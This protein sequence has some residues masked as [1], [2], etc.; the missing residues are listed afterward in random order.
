MASK[1]GWSIAGN[2]PQFGLFDI[3]YG[4]T[5]KSAPG[6]LVDVLSDEG[7]KLAPETMGMVIK[8]H[9]LKNCIQKFGIT[10]RDFVMHAKKFD[11]YYDTS[12]AG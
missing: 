6:F 4:S 8:L 5:G 3:M 9:F 7:E 10:K 12:D 2:F 1:T 11:G